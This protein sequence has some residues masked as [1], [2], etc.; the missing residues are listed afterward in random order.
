[1][2]VPLALPRGAAALSFGTVLSQASWLR[3][4]MWYF[5]HLISEQSA[6]TYCSEALANDLQAEQHAEVFA[7]A[8]RERI[9]EHCHSIL[10]T[11]DVGKPVAQIA[12]S[13]VH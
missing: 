2:Y 8:F 10:V 11:T 1:V 9:G 13:P 4:E 6:E 12:L 7:G 3:S 5:F